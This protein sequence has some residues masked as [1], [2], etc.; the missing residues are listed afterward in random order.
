MRV[1]YGSLAR[2]AYL[3]CGDTDN[4]EDLVQTVLA[5]VYVRWGR[6]RDHENVPAYV[7]TALTRTYISDRR[8]KGFGE[9][10]SADIASSVVLD[11]PIRTID[12]RDELRVALQSLPARQRTAL[13]LRYYHRFSEA[14]TARLLGCSV[15]GVKALTRRGLQGVRSTSTVT[16]KLRK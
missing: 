3:L 2:S 14:E 15:S 11:D 7:Q 4:A 9:R 10:P 8:R 13:V 6:V 5:K 16:E 1:S 12:D